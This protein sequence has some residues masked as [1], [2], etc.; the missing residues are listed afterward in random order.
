MSKSILIAGCAAAVLALA[1]AA[2]AAVA[3]LPSLAEP[4]LSPD[5]SEIAFASGGDI[6]TVPAPGG[7]AR[8]LVTD[9]ATESRPVYSPDGSRLAFVST[10]SGAAD[11]YVLTFSTGE[12]KR[13]TWSDVGQALDGWS[14]DGK[15]LYFTS[16]QND[17]RGQGD[18]FRVPADGGTPLEVSRER[19]LNEFESA[20]SPDGQSVALMARGLSNAQWW[21]NGHSH[22]DETELWLKPISEAGGYRKLLPGGAKH[23]WPMWSP[24]G[25]ALYYM[26]DE[27][28]AENIWKLPIGGA[29]QQV[30]RFIDGRVLWPQIGYDGR[31]IVFERNFAIWRL[32][33]GSGQTAQVPVALRGAPASAGTR[34]LNETSFGQLSLSPDGK[35]AAVIAHGEVF[36]VSAKDG[37]A[38][39]RISRSPAAEGEVDW[40]PDSGSVVYVSERGLDSHLVRY[41]FDKGAEEV[42]TANKGLDA[43]PTHSPDGRMVA[44]VHGARELHVLTLAANGKPAKDVVVFT[45]PLGDD[46]P[47]LAWSPDSQWLAFTL[48]DRK[49]FR[50][51]NVIPAAGGGARPISFLANGQTG[52]KIA[53]SPDG[54]FILFDTAQRSEDARMVR[55]DLLP[56]VPKYREDAF[57]ELFKPGTTPDKPAEPASPP[58]PAKEDAAGGDKSDLKDGK[59]A[60]SGKAKKARPEPVKIVFEGIRER[61]TIL[62]LGMDAEAPVIS[63]DG[64]TL[65]YLTDQDGQQNLY[66]YSLDELAKE[67]PSPVQL[68]TTRKAKSGYAFTPDSK[69]VF[70]LDGGAVFSTSVESPKAKPLAANA[71]MDVDFDAEKMVVFDE[72]WRALN[73]GFFDANF[74]GKDWAGLRAR[75]EPYVAGA[76]TGDELRRDINLMIGELNASHSGIGKGAD[77]PDAIKPVPV[78]NLGLRF[79]RQPYEAGRGLVIREVVAL[80]PAAIEGTIVPGE[81]LVSVNHKPVGPGVDLDSLLTGE[82]GKKTVLGI[83]SAKDPA[84]VREAV[85]RPVAAGAA[86]GLLYRQWVNDRRAYVEKASGGRLGYVHIPDMGGPSLQQLYLDLDAQNQEKQGVVIDLRN[87]NGGFI[88]GYALDVFSRR[89]FLTMEP[90]DLFALP[91]RQALGQR[92]LGAPTVLVINESSLSDAEDFT[93]GYRALGLGKVVGQPTAGWIIY[94]SPERLI[95]GSAVRVPSTRIR[96]LKGEDMEMHPRPVDITVE[97]PLG[98]TVA[99]KDAQ[100]DAAVAELLKEPR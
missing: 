21:R 66:A 45:G 96:D 92:A 24:D 85:V 36:A 17:V 34:H 77:A 84:K 93:E 4:A 81:T 61:A 62:P 5:G 42:L 29:P 80:G 48:V 67:P 79:E 68:T 89:N 18:I 47:T 37:G 71:E 91:S 2:R 31:S 94:T 1:G 25:S 33:L 9:P 51:V 10:R 8:L 55:V 97:R 27:S 88:N 58:A 39:Q 35:K 43:S 95:D 82:V 20:P 38:A 99:G 15:W 59:E 69:E 83:G 73:R 50:N 11:I 44:Y 76:R 32:D 13:I 98:E 86:G 57:R 74:N 87:N 54:R 40:A 26:S 49:S 53:W 28:G 14:R 41:D 78:G 46:R 72:A 12:V 7:Q 56:H 22:I 64:K 3:P 63:P 100:L 60:A 6:W 75:W 19:Y 52:G 90:R 30:T 65:V 23:A 70:Y 16:G